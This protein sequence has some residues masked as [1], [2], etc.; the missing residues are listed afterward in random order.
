MDT[1][2]EESSA[3]RTEQVKNHEISALKDGNRMNSISPLSQLLDFYEE[4]Q[5]TLFYVW[6]CPVLL[7]K[8]NLKQ[9]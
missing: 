2:R 8:F 5:K 1:S 4:K 6:P 3:L 9:K 7:T